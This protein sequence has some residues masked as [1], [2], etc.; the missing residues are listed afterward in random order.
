MSLRKFSSFAVVSGTGWL[1]DV[2][3]TLALVAAGLAPFWGSVLGSLTAVSFVFVVS[4]L[5]TFDVERVRTDRYAPYLLWHAVTLPLASALVA[6][7]AGLI[8][9]PVAGILPRLPEGVAAALPGPLALAAGLA[10]VAVTPV[11]LT[12]NFLFMRWLVERRAG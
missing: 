10:K 11:T 4:Q 1:I 9:G 5:A 3:L 12:A 6:G 8:E 2:G 7:L